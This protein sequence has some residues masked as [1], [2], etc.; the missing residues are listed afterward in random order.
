MNPLN[1]DE[2]SSKEPQGVDDRPARL[3]QKVFS[4][5]Q[6]YWALL[7]PYIG[8]ICAPYIL[9]AS[10]TLELSEEEAIF[11][12]TALWGCA[13]STEKRPY[14]QLNDVNKTT[15]CCFLGVSSALNDGKPISPGCG[16]NETLVDELVMELQ[17][18]KEGR[19]NIAQVK[20]AERAFAL[21]RDMDTKLDKIMTH[22]KL[23]IPPPAEQMRLDSER[24]LENKV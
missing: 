15:C 7:I 18:R 1:N 9:T 8:C 12:K 22:L 2:R 16:C 19:G 3:G 11:H 17:K 20:I 6:P 4:N 10:F 13:N 23:P 14:A 24:L 5:L 21:Q